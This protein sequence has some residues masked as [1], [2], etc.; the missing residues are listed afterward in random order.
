MRHVRNRRFGRAFAL[1]PRDELRQWIKAVSHGGS[2]GSQV[3]RVD[4]LELDQDLHFQRR[5]WVAER[6]GWFTIAALLV[7]ALLGVFGSGPLSSAS[8]GGDL[9]RIDYER[10]GRLLTPVKL[11]VQLGEGA[12]AGGVARV[13]IASH[14]LESMELQGIT[15]EP[16]ATEVL[17]DRVGFAFHIAEGGPGV[18]TFHM[19]PDRFGTLTG[20]VGLVDGPELRFWQFVYP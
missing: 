13:W 16:D 1:P 18:V 3:Q 8:S 4:A 20:R 5:E 2:S 11:R 9:M 14:Y 7:A 17:A 19:R 10:F 15:P 12:S 6:I